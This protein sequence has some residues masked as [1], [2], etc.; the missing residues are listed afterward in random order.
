MARIARKL[1]LS[2]MDKLSNSLINP[3]QKI[4]VLLI[5][6]SGSLI[7]SQYAGSIYADLYN[8]V[9]NIRSQ[10]VSARVIQYEFVIERMFSPSM[11][12]G[13]LLRI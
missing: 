5:A 7:L 1:V 2:G 13:F 3:L 8:L 4:M 6:M 10:G 11:P 12:P 9:F